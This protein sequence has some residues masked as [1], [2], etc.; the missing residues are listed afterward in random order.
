[1]K[2]LILVGVITDNIKAFEMIL[3]SKID[4]QII[5]AAGGV[6][7]LANILFGLKIFTSYSSWHNYS[8]FKSDAAGHIVLNKQDIIDNTE[9]KW[10]KDI[11][12]INP[13]R[14]EL[15]MWEGKQVVDI[16]EATRQL[17]K[18][19]DDKELIEQDLKR[20]GITGKSMAHAL[21]VAD[22]QAIED[23]K[24]YFYIKDAVNN[25][26][27]IDTKKIEGTWF[28]DSPKS[29]QFVIQ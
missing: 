26:V 2:W 22:R 12:A 23:K 27:R 19:Y 1:V 6:N 10:E 14:F 18:L 9:L 5:D 3:P 16:I 20:H 17:L 24:F 25:S 13:T 28:D 29:Y 8:F 4:I 21:L 7:L 15:Y 11:Q